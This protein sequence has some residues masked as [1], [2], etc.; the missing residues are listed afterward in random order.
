MKLRVKHV[1]LLVYS[2]I[3]TSLLL[4]GCETTVITT[5]TAT[6]TTTSTI[7]L[8]STISPSPPTSE[9]SISSSAVLPS[10]TDLKFE[11]LIIGGIYRDT[12]SIGG[13]YKDITNVPTGIY[14]LANEQ[15]PLPKVY[16]SWYPD[17]LEILNNFDFSEYFVILVF[18]GTQ[19]VAGPFINTERIWQNKDIIYVLADF[20]NGGPYH[21]DAVSAPSQSMKVSKSTMTQFGTITFIL[22]DLSGKERARAIYD[23]SQ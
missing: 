19:G 14:V 13:E 16:T 5:T 2:L 17:S 6:R 1:K 7:T 3:A 4:T 8:T 9:T 18:M 20:N 23:V 21:L 22:L 11:V 10:G 12:P 15:S